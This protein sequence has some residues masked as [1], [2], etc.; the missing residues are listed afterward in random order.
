MRLGSASARG[1]LD[2][3]ERKVQEPGRLD[4]GWAETHDEKIALLGTFFTQKAQQFAAMGVKD[5][6]DVHARA[7][8]RTLALL[9]WGKP[10]RLRLGYIKL[11]GEVLAIFSG[12]VCH[13]RMS[14]AL[15]SLTGGGGTRSANC[16]AHF[17]VSDRGSVECGARSLRPWLGPG[18][19]QRTNS[20]TSFSRCSTAS[21]PSRY[22]GSF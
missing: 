5:I 3:K 20:G 9:E 13:D 4:F 2:R 8:Y 6:F 11:D 19:A 10:S 21:S 15:S 17:A 1:T 18:P 7:F 22:K 12:T 16:P 14:V